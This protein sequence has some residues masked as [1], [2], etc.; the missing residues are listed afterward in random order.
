MTKRALLI[1][2]TVLA[3]T[4]GCSISASLHGQESKL[5]PIIPASVFDVV[6]PPARP[7]SAFAKFQNLKRSLLAI[8]RIRHKNSAGVADWYG[9]GIVIR[10]LDGNLYILSNQH[11]CGYPKDEGSI[12]AEF[13]DSTGHK[14]IGFFKVEVLQAIQKGNIDAAICRLPHGETLAHIPQLPLGTDEVK[15]N[16]L[17][18]QCGCDGAKQVNQSLGYVLK[19]EAG[20]IFYLPSSY[21][22]DS[23]SAIVSEDGLRTVALV[24]WQARLDN[25]EGTVGLAQSVPA[26]VN[27]FKKGTFERLPNNVFS[28]GFQRWR[29][30]RPQPRPTSPLV[31]QTPPIADEDLDNIFGL[32]GPVA[33]QPS[34]DNETPEVTPEAPQGPEMEEETLSGGPLRKLLDRLQR[35]QEDLKEGQKDER[36]VIGGLIGKMNLIETALTWIWRVV[37]AVVILGCIGLFAQQG[38]L[39]RI[40]VTFVK[41]VI[42]L[43]KAAIAVV[44]DAITK[45]LPP[46]DASVED[47]LASI[48]EELTEEL[49]HEGETP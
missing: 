9:S 25:I 2:L 28:M 44:K 41:L 13:M 42:R 19:R 15:P 40:V 11:V 34:D 24:A 23:G 35:N 3:I 43:T 20:L 46:K 30:K 36:G 38:W 6:D 39:L 29:W 45:P 18:V 10:K 32:D 8:V 14:S 12:E 27:A 49:N 4:A 16:D 21:S 1:L 5:N 48:R 33:P 37:I 47:Q 22:G 26:V 31:P 17:I 7:V